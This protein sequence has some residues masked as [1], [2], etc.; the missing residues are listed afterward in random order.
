MAWVLGAEIR[1]DVL[2]DGRRVVS[3]ELNGLQRE[4]MELGWVEDIKFVEMRIEEIA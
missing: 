3:V 1:D 2:Y 4:F